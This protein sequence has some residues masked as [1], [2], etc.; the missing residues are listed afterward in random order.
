MNQKNKFLFE[1]V[2][3]VAAN[4]EYFKFKVFEEPIKTGIDVE[5]VSKGLKNIGLS[6]SDNNP[7]NINRI[8]KECEVSV[9]KKGLKQLMTR[10]SSSSNASDGRGF[11]YTTDPT[12]ENLSMM[13][14][15][16]A[17]LELLEQNHVYYVASHTKTDEFK[18]STIG[19][20]STVFKNA[21]SMIGDLSNGHADSTQ[22]AD[23]IAASVEAL[24]ETKEQ[25]YHQVDEDTIFLTAQPDEEGNSTNVA[26]IYYKYDFEI[27]D[28]ANKK[29]KYHQSK[30]SITQKN[31][32]F[33]SP[34][35]FRK[36]FE[37]VVKNKT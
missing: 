2:T 4:R 18:S 31:I 23:N 21:A 10:S 37:W 25:N 6:C 30:Y 5:A 12:N 29:E 16:L 34:E 22:V 24:T 14:V 17:N 7:E 33:S 26:G 8:Y 27:K 35:I 28:Y 15:I 11:E 3:A 20:I 36:V 32:V 13:Q 1:D 9:S 19:T